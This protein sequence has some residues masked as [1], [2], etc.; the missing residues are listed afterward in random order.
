M[1]HRQP[2]FGR[3]AVTRYATIPI[4]YDW[5]EKQ[6]TIVSQPICEYKKCWEIPFIR[7]TF[8]LI[9]IKVAQFMI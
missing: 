2:F 9:E 3:P 8:L 1:R 4:L 7:L 5:G 6:T